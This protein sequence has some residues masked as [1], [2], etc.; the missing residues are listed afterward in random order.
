MK[1]IGLFPAILA[2]IL[3]TNCGIEK[4]LVGLWQIEKVKI[5]NQEMT[6]MAR[7]TRLN[8]NKSQES[9]NGWFQHTIGQWT[10]DAQNNTIAITNSN[11][12]KDEFEGFTINKVD[13]KK[14]IWSREEEGEQVI[15]TLKKTNKLPQATSN[16]LL[17][18]WLLKTKNEVKLEGSASY[19]FLRW[20]RIVVSRQESKSKQYGT[21][22][23]HGHKEELQIIYYEEPLRQEIWSYQFDGKN[24]LILEEINEKVKLEYERIDYIPK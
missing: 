8:K 6:P 23:T 18:V 14:M 1:Y 16:R 7:W 17:G 9:G 22:K 11:G 5:G 20:D 24:H 15:V 10:Y 19:I 21:Y 2:L 3:F 4:K 12:V 13:N